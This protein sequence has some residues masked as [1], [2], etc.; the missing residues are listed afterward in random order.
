ML[1]SLGF[2][3]SEGGE[4]LGWGIPVMARVTMW[5]PMMLA[6]AVCTT[7]RALSV[8]NKPAAVQADDREVSTHLS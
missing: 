1:R 8:A 4:G 3:P 5:A 2:E 7:S 6:Q